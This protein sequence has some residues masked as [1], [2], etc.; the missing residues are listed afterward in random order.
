MKSCSAKKWTVNPSGVMVNSRYRVVHREPE[1][2]VIHNT[3]DIDT[4]CELV[5]VLR[6]SLGLQQLIVP[7][8]IVLIFQIGKQRYWRAK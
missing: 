3:L 4:C 7:A 5:V 1:D 6:A 2:I 8:T